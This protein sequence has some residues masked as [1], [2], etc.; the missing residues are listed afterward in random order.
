MALGLW[1]RE[2][3]SLTAWAQ[4]NVLGTST[5][6]MGPGAC[7]ETLNNQWSSWN[8]QKVVGFRMF[9]FVIEN[10]SFLIGSLGSL[11]LKR[12]KDAYAM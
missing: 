6:E 5:C 4:T 12:L 3:T 9:H 1:S 2:E 10:R 8:F 11:F 7:H